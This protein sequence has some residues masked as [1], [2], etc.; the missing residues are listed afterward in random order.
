MQ[1]EVRRKLEMAERVSAFLAAHPDEDPGYGAVRAAF[2]ADRASADE[3]AARAR[4]GQVEARAA[5]TAKREAR[6]VLQRQLLQH[7]ARVGEAAAQERPDLVGRFRLPTTSRAV[8]PFVVAA[9]T[10]IAEAGELAGLL[11]KYGMSEVVFG[12]LSTTLAE[13]ERAT[14]QARTARLAHVGA[15]AELRVVAGELVRH[16]ARLDGHNQVRY[17]RDPEVLAAWNA[18]RVVVT[19]RRRGRQGVPPAGETPLAA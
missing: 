8:K 4:S 18:A 1:A 16:V 15:Y 19:V 17:R 2:E 12:E 10:I 5:V 11:R 6:L 9:R 3:L 13:L 7:L 14:G